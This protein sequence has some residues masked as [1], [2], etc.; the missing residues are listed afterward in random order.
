MFAQAAGFSPT[1]CRFDSSD[2][3]EMSRTIG[4]PTNADKWTCSWWQ[5]RTTAGFFDMVFSGHSTGEIYDNIFHHQAD[6]T[7]R[8]EAQNG[9]SSYSVYSTSG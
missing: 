6:N 4:T 7:I 9:T 1:A 3:S 8:R 5:K 2:T